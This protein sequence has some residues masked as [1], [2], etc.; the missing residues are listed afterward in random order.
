MHGFYRDGK[1]RFGR[2]FPGCR[3]GLSLPTDS[4]ARMGNC[5]VPL[6]DPQL[7]DRSGAS[8]GVA[9]GLQD[10]VVSAPDYGI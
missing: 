8:D 3:V 7:D 10:F 4:S 9:G 5:E 2:I 1:A 6:A